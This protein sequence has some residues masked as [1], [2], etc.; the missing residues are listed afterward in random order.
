[1]STIARF[2]LVIDSDNGAHVRFRLFAATGGQHLGGAG[3]LVMRVDEYAA[4]RKLLKPVLVDVIPG[5]QALAVLA[6]VAAQFGAVDMLAEENCSYRDDPG[7]DHEQCLDGHASNIAAIAADLS[8]NA[9]DCLRRT[10]GDFV[11]KRGP[12]PAFATLGTIRSLRDLGLIVYTGDDHHLTDQGRL[13]V[14]QLRRMQEAVTDR[15]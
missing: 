1:M 4:F 8:L 15:G 14:E 11:A 6:D 5:E 13:V 10:A 3:H 9:Q 2:G 12:K 7:H